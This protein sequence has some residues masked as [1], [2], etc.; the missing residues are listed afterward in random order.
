FSFD[1]SGFQRHAKRFDPADL[2]R[3]MEG[4]RLLVTGANSGLGRAAALRLAH[5][6]AEVWLLCRSEERGRRALEDLKLSSGNPSL[7]LE[8]ID[9]SDLASVE[10]FCARHRGVEIDALIHNAGIL[11]S[12]RRLTADDL[13]ATWATNVTGPFALTWRLA[14]NLRL[15]AEK[16]GEARVINVTSGGMYTQKMNLDDVNWERRDFDGVEAYAQTK[17]AEVILTELW[18]ER[19]A[20]AGIQVHSMHPGWAD[21]P[22]VREAL[23]RFYR[24]TKNRLRTPREGADTIVYLAAAPGLRETSGQ[25]YFDRRPAPTHAF[26]WTR[27]SDTVRHALW[28]LCREQAGLP[29]GAPPLEDKEEAL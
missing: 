19:F 9:V 21:T 16:R 23:P 17:R 15:A 3:S 6:G 7:R 5:L 18:A 2:D 4:R 10:D 13:E 8:L 14:P 22:A 12:E 29:D 26:P 27:E 1:R 11:P 28:Q 24:F 20:G 25:L